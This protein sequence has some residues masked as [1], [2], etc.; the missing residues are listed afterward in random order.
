MN[1]KLPPEAFDYYLSLGLARSYQA[2][3][4]KYGV[5]KVAVTNLATKEQWQERIARIEAKAREQGEKKAIETREEMNERFLR[6][7]QVVERRALEGLRNFTFDSAIDAA[8]AL[9]LA[10]K[11][12]RLIRGEPTERTESV[13]QIIRREYERWLKP[14]DDDGEQRGDGGASGGDQAA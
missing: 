14:V 4:E 2:V 8:R 10:T 12:A 11:N 9:D 13:E 5:S 6:V 1:R 3:A 7:W